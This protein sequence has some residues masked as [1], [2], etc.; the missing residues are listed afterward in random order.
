MAH[1]SVHVRSCF[2]HPARR[3]VNR[4]ILHVAG[5]GFDTRRF[6]DRWYHYCVSALTIRNHRTTKCWPVR[7]QNHPRFSP[8]G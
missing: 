2:V 4:Y 1:G 5:H 3:C 8:T 6:P 7:I